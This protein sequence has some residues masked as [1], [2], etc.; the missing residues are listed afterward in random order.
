MARDIILDLE[1]LNDDNEK[2]NSERGGEW[3]IA[4]AAMVI[5]LCVWGIVQAVVWKGT[6]GFFCQVG[7]A[8][9]ARRM[10]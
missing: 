8:W 1:P 10:V 2:S 7:K 4:G 9:E 5:V 6:I 3:F